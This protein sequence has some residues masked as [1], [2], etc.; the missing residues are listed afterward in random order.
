MKFSKFVKDLVSDGVLVLNV[1]GG[2]ITDYLVS[3]SVSR[4]VIYRTGNGISAKPLTDD[5]KII[6]INA[7]GDLM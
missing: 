5:E 6:N 1:S 4:L 2:E 7:A 3:G